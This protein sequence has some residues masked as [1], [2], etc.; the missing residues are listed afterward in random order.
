MREEKHL[1]T[2][3]EV[4]ARLKCMG[5]TLSKWTLRNY[6]Q[7]HGWGVKKKSHYLYDWDKIKE[8]YTRNPNEPPEGWVKIS[9]LAKNC[10]NLKTGEH[11]SA[12]TVNNY[13]GKYNPDAA[14][15]GPTPL[16][17]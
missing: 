12:S 13:L 4:I 3:G 1:I 6:R 5:M 8:Y 15:A 17:E 7:I 10:I 2:R 16:S 14:K 11:Y 9:E